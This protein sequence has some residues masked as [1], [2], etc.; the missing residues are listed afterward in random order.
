[1][2]LSPFD[3]CD[4]ESGRGRISEPTYRLSLMFTLGQSLY[5]SLQITAGFKQPSRPYA[6]QR[7]VQI[8]K[9]AG[10]A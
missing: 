10:N 9:G 8:Q 4:E 1:M 2:P 6:A 3:Y 5:N 7:Q